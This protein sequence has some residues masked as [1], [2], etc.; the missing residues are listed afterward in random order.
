MSESYPHIAGSIAAT[1]AYIARASLTISIHN[2]V[3]LGRPT[4]QATRKAGRD[5]AASKCGC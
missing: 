3:K 1:Q 4:G 5:D 2:E